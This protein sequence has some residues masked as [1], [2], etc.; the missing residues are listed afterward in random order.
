M[1]GILKISVLF[2]SVI[3]FSTFAK[4]VDSLQLKAGLL[5][6]IN[7]SD[8]SYKLIEFN[9]N[10]QHRLLT[11]KITSAFEKVKFRPFTDDD[12]N[13]SISECIINIANQ[14]NSNENTRLI[15]T[16][17]L[18]DSFNVIEISTNLD[19]QPIYTE[20]YQLDKQ[21]NNSTARE[22]IHMYKDRIES[23]KL[24]SNNEFYGFW[25]GVLNINGKPEL[26]SFEAHP[27]KTSYFIRFVNGKSFTNKTSFSPAG[28]KK[29]DDM[30]NITTDHRSFANKLLIH[31][32]NSVLEG[33]MYSI[34]KGVTL[35]TGIFRLYRIKITE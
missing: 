28:V 10:G 3:C 1:F 19:G 20:T 8:F 16:P 18:D 9:S 21:Q 15:I 32:N 31:K 5:E 27:D 26:L 17:Y 12:I 7:E 25:V 29:T 2:V 30:I 14:N 35:Q 33:Y 23:L 6:G 11:L 4:Q 24:I 34:H 13:C 22:F